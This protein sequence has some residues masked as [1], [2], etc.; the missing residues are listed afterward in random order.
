MT[1]VRDR[2]GKSW[3]VS[4]TAVYGLAACLV[5][6]T[7]PGCGRWS[8][9]LACGQDDCTFTDRE[10]T[11]IGKLSPTTW[12]EPTCDC[13][14]R[15]LPFN[16]PTDPQYASCWT[17][18]GTCRDDAEARRAV[19]FEPDK[20]PAV[21]LGWALYYDPRLSGPATWVDTLGRP[22]VSARAPSKDLT[23]ISC[24]T[25]HDPAR[26]GSDF[27]SLPGHVSIGAGWYDVN[28]QQTLN[29]AYFPLLYWNGRADS[30]WA[31]AAQV[32]ESNVSMNGDRQRTA[33]VI[34]RE[35]AS[36]DAFSYR[37][38]YAQLFDGYPDLLDAYFRDV[39]TEACGKLP[40][41][42]ASK[43]P[44]AV[45]EAMTTVHANVAMA[46]AAYEWYLR[47]RDAPFDAFVQEGPASSALSPAAKRGLKLFVGR[48]SCIDCHSGPLLS[49][50]KFHDIGIAQTGTN[51]PTVEDCAGPPGSKCSCVSEE[52][53]ETCLPWGAYAGLQKL[54]GPSTVFR[55]L[56]TYSLWK[57]PVCVAQDRASPGGP[58]SDAGT[59]PATSPDG[60]VDEGRPR[61]ETWVCSDRPPTDPSFKG[62]WR[63]PSLRDVALTAPYMHNGSLAT[64][65]DVVW[66][67]DQ[68]VSGALPEAPS[69]LL[70]GGATPVANQAAPGAGTP[71]AEL[72]PLR[73]SSQDRADLVAF[74]RTLT[75]KPAYPRLH[76]CPPFAGASCA[77]NPVTAMGAPPVTAAPYPCAT[78]DAAVA[79]DAAAGADAGTSDGG[80][81]GPPAADVEGTLTP[82]PDGSAD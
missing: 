38:R 8:D 35:R 66:H 42:D 77:T 1:A 10:W 57:A 43:I 82:G 15:A 79:V 25:C 71:A 47:S 4:P 62:R 34:A 12:P 63:T 64:L 2:G 31:Q 18:G 80:G 74:L 36:A 60:G 23:N 11:E 51:V 52:K 39:S 13:S 73:L 55:R 14:N 41:A 61:A 49:D 78:N 3:G 30:L 5:A 81:D 45:W 9:Q 48:A 65:E 7:A 32:M 22:T 59:A 44:T 37:E 26:A 76:T 53:A 68:G 17:P 20:D 56:S 24:A 54:A 69:A 28:V 50:G 16:R 72:H 33:C 75:G 40:K 6:L 67:Y 70:C 27:T 46:I 19:D 29:A 58:S 21:E